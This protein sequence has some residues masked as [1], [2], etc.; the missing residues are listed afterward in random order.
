M[1]SEANA[2]LVQ[3]LDALNAS[4]PSFECPGGCCKCCGPVP[5][6]KMEANRLGLNRMYT[7]GKGKFGDTCEFVNEQNQCA[8]YENRPFICRFFNS[9]FAGVFKC[10][11]TP[12]NGY[13]TPKEADAAMNA[14]FEII[15]AEGYTNEFMAANDATFDVMKAREERN[16]WGSRFYGIP[17]NNQ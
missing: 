14:Y 5:M 4:L 10:N 1:N 2:T 17:K 16:G 7:I 9:A 8:V 12:V 13:L 3:Q 11:E 6:S 15:V